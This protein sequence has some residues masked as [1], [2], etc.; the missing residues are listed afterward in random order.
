VT[1]RLVTLHP[2]YAVAT[3]PHHVPR[4]RTRDAV[5]ASSRRAVH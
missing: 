2:G 4:V 5:F 1:A 3:V